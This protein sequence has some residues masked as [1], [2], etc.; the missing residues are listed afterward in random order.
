MKTERQSLNISFR[1]TV[2]VKNCGLL[3]LKTFLILIVFTPNLLFSQTDNW[4]QVVGNGFEN[5]SQNT[6][7]EMEVFN[8]YIYASTSPL[9]AGIAKLYRSSTGDAG[10][11]TNI[12]IPLNG[13]KSIHSFGTTELGGGYI[14]CGTGNPTIGAMI[15]QSQDG[16]TWTPIANRGFGNP[17]LATSAPHMVVFQGTGDTSPYLYAGIG[18]HGAGYKAEVWRIPYTS[19]NPSDWVKI[20]D[21]D[22][23]STTITDSVDLIS[24][25]CLWNNKIYF[26]TNAKGQLW[27]STDGTHFTQNTGV[28][29][30]FGIN[31]NIVLSSIAVFNDTMYITTTNMQGGQLW[32]SGDGVSWQKITGNAFGKGVAVNELRSLRASFGKLW[33]TGYTDVNYSNGTPIWKS[34]DGFNFTQSNADGFGNINNNGQN[35]VV[36]G[37]GNHEY[38]GGPNYQ[39]GG[40]VWR[41]DMTTDVNMT[42]IKENT[43]NIFPNPFSEIAFIEYQSKNISTCE[44]NIYNINGELVKTI[45]PDSNNKFIIKKEILNSGIYL[46]SLTENQKVIKSGKFIIE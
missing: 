23:V 3:L 32:R 33:V 42:E 35:A 29:Y 13:D 4:V 38:F 15:Y 11:W 37:F 8:G 40:Q 24:Y 6:V 1:L 45:K 25:F 9:S 16:S 28:G 19:T 31:A 20:I 27:E 17:N 2:Q 14:W 18:S 46:Y 30:G 44:V 39:D 43:V 7:P 41:L 22:T 36:I 12:N 26:G 21:F 5:S 10:T 34:S